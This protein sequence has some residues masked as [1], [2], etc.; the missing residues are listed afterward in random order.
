M[1]WIASILQ[2]LAT[3]AA[4]LAA[5][6]VAIQIRD[7]RRFATSEFIHQLDND[8]QNHLGV[9]KKLVVPGGEWTKPDVKDLTPEE[10]AELGTYVSFFEKLHFLIQKKAVSMEAID[11]MFSGR[12]FMMAQNRVVQKEIF[13][14]EHLGRHF[15]VVRELYGDWIELLQARNDKLPNFGPCLLKLLPNSSPTHTPER[16]NG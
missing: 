4:A 7:S 6:A 5:G 16:R 9:Y 2:F 3:L 13:L 8:I 11:T 10:I 14:N 1:S 15:D 12:F